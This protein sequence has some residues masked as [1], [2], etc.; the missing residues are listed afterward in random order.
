MTAGI[1]SGEPVA[2]AFDSQIGAAIVRSSGETTVLPERDAV[3]EIARIERNATPRWVWW[4][5]STAQQLIE[6]GIRP[7]RCWDLAVVHHLVHGGWRSTPATIWATC[8][9]LD[10]SRL[11]ETA[12]VD[13]FTVTDQ[14]DKP[15]EPIRG[16]LRPDW[17]EGTWC[18]NLDHLGSWAKLIVDVRTCQ[19]NSIANLADRPGASATALSESP[20]RISRRTINGRTPT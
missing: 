8:K 6:N 10:L 17:V 18:E 19:L 7:V 11:P 5:K 14:L 20:L 9:G 15:H 12:P 3:K 2:L 13:L 1:E 4:S 16:Y